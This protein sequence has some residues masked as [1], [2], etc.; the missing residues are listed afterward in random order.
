MWRAKPWNLSNYYTEKYSNLILS[1]QHETNLAKRS[2]IYK[3]LN[4]LQLE[5][6]FI[7]VITPIIRWWAMS[8]NIEGFNSNLD[9]MPILEKVYIK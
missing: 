2:Q 1:G 3:K 4:K 9:S 5:E 6:S 7:I 8:E